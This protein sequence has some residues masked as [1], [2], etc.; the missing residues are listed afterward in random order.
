[1]DMELRCN[2]CKHKWNYKG[3]NPYYAPCPYCYG[4]VKVV[5]G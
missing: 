4:R 3:K 2:K 1:M 5:K